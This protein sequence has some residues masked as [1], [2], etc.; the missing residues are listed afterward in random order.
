VGAA[1]LV[2]MYSNWSSIR[3]HVDSAYPR[4]LEHIA[5]LAV[6]TILAAYA[7]LRG[8]EVR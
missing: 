7:Q 5:P 1:T 3:L 6:A 8:S 2:F 4:L